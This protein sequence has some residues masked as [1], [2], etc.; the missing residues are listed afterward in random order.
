MSKR[1]YII[2]GFI[3][4]F[5]GILGAFL[6]LLPTTPFLLLTAALF[7]KSSPKYY[8]KLLNNKWCGTYIRNYRNGNGIPIYAK[9]MALT[10]LWVTIT[11]SIILTDMS[12]FVDLFIL[13]IAS[14]V[15]V[16]ILRLKT[17][18]SNKQELKSSEKITSFNDVN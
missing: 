10:L 17:S 6:P 16:H 7:A 9:I 8:Q 18:R 13:I 14:G 15:T 1:I 2:L 4:L 3:S 12:L 5:L 11:S